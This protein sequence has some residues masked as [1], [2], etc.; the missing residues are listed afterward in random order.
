MTWSADFPADDWRSIAAR[1][2]RPPRD[3]AA[4]GQGQG[5]AAPARHPAGH[6]AGAAVLLKELKARGYRIVHVVPAERRPSEDGDAAVAM[7]DESAARI[8]PP[9]VWPRTMA[10]TAR[11]HGAAAP[12]RAG[13]AGLRHRRAGRDR[14]DDRLADR[15]R[16]PATAAAEGHACRAGRGARRLPS[17]IDLV[18]ARGTAGARTRKAS[19]IPACRPLR[20]VPQSVPRCP[21]SRSRSAT[22]A[23]RDGRHRDTGSIGPRPGRWPVTTASMPKA[24]FPDRARD[25]APRRDPGRR[26]GHED[27]PRAAAGHDV[28]GTIAV[29]SIANRASLRSRSEAS[30]KTIGDA[31]CTIHSTSPGPD[32]CARSRPGRRWR[33][34]PSAQTV[35]APDG[36]DPAVVM[37]DTGAVR[38]VVHDGVREFKG[39]PYARP[40]VGKLRWALPR[41]AQPWTR[42]PATP[43]TTAAPARRS[44]A[45]ASPRRATTRTACTLNITAPY[46][47]R[48]RPRAQARR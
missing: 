18:V 3:R 14:G 25:G 2:D 13:R 23:A 20:A 6:R 48:A 32:C 12:R 11:R 22:C 4:R 26:T 37:T 8:R 28:Q 27:R 40:P 16:A 5:R 17:I 1:R 38:G 41:P 35:A 29:R 34:A 39:I 36:R 33:P 24:G 42:R 46:A 30:A 9:I 43:A 47:G 19:A 7:A 15:S 45:T 44:R 31:R 21:R 10:A